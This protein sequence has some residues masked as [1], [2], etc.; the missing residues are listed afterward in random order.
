MASIMRLFAKWHIWLAWL[1][2]IPILMWTL[3]GLVMVAK[4]IEEVR[5]TKLMREVPQQNIPKDITIAVTLPPSTEKP[6]QSVRTAM[7]H[8]ELIT[9]INYS[10][11]T[12]L[13]LREDG[14]SMEP[15]S[16]LEARMIVAEQ[17]VGGD[18]VVS[19]R[20]FTADG[21]PFDFRRPMPVWQVVL[22]GGTNVYV[23]T[24]TGRIEAVRTK[25][26]RTFDFMWGLHIMDL[27]EREDTSHPI[28]IL[29][30]ALSVIASILGTVL[31]FRKRKAR[32]KASTTD[33]ESAE[34]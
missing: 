3:T 4:P 33:P 8:G 18:K 23:G 11:G 6:V 16:E 1:T 5:G 7:E 19:T 17:V 10:D 26:W 15:L 24:E 20:R 27:Q 21:V 13:R 32:V 31:M 29:F 2:G 34:A 14:T 12:S 30:A 9:R 28:L 25:W 22:E